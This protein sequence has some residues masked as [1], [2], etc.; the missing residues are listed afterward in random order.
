MN[1]QA[2]IEVARD[3]AS[4]TY[5]DRDL[6]FVDS[7]WDQECHAWFVTIRVGD[8]LLTE[9]DVREGDDGSLFARLERTKTE[10]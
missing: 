4:D 7:Y 6:V 10:A 2:A 9:W 8:S 5:P 1:D 3:A